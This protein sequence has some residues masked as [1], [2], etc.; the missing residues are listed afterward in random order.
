MQ[1]VNVEIRERRLVFYLHCHQCAWSVDICLIDNTQYL[2][3][4]LILQCGLR[5]D[6]YQRKLDFRL[7]PRISDFCHEFRE[8][9]E[10]KIHSP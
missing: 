6:L 5:S 4:P 8:I 7:L 10:L 2:H 9:L 3:A 1:I